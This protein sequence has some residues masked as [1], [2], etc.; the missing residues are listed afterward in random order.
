MPRIVAFCHKSQ[1]FTMNVEN[2]FLESCKII[3]DFNYHLFRTK[4]YF[5]DFKHIITKKL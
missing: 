3:L 1:H 2:I 4:K 5:G